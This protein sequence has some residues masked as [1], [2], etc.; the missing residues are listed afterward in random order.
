MHTKHFNFLLFSIISLA[1]CAR[2]LASEKPNIILIVSD[3]AGYADFGFQ[4]SSEIKTPHIDRLAAGGV[5]FTQAYVSASVCCPSRMGIMTGRYQQRFGAECNVPKL[6]TPGY[7]EADL[8][9]DPQESTMGDL[10][11]AAGYRTLMV[12]KWHLGIEDHHHPMNRGFD[13]FYGFLGG[14]RSYRALESTSPETRLY[15]D[16]EPL[17]EDDAVSYLTEDL[18]EAAIEFIERDDA[19]PFFIYLSYNAVHT[20]M[21]AKAEDIE[22]SPAIGDES[23]RTYAAMTRSMD[24]NIG[25][26][27]AHLEESGLR[28]NTLF[29]FANDNG[30]A[31]N[32]AS[33]NS[34]L[35]GFK[36]SYWEGGIRI[37]MI[38]NWEKRIRPG[39]QFP[40]PVSTLDILPTFLAAAGSD[41]RGKPLD[42]KDLLPYLSG[43][44]AGPPHEFLFWRLWHVAAVRHEDWKLIRVADHP[45]KSQRE[46]LSAPLLF[47]LAEDPGE[48]SNIASQHPAVTEMLMKRL[49]GWESA[50]GTPRWYDGVDWPKW[51]R[52]Q[53]ENHKLENTRY[54]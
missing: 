52:I 37:P 51:G 41:A 19:A 46:L 36:G 50:L 29:C 49:E 47:N 1:C 40:A 9:L 22:Q 13:S 28:E 12:G 14:S 3:D 34:P 6:P 18:T 32:N 33:A 30:G 20:P 54:R 23:R 25:R 2:L 45:L 17:D 11:A 43:E 21:E 27:V 10:L 5:T 42:G 53:I 38:L 4:G 16:F 26:L 8:G 15:S 39:S 24:E 35:R 7:S 44:A 48:T 31:T